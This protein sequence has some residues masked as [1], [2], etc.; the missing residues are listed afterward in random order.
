M[1]V[2]S[3]ISVGV[4]NKSYTHN[5]SFDNNT[6]C[7]FGGVQPLFSQYLSA[8]DKLSGN[9]RQ[10]VR[11]SPMPVP[12][13]GRMRLVNKLRFVP[14]V[15]V[16]PYFEAMLANQYVSNSDTNYLPTSVPL[17]QCK[18][19]TMIVLSRF[20][21]CTYYKGSGNLTPQNVS[22]TDQAV[23]FFDNMTS[24]QLT[25]LGLTLNLTDD[26]DAITFDGAD[27]V[28]IDDSITQALTFRLTDM[29]KRLRSIM[30]GLGYVFDLDSSDNVSLLPL[31]AY[32]KAYFDA[33]VPKR[34]MQW[35][36]TNCFVLIDEIFQNYVTNFGSLYNS[37]KS[38]VKAAAKEFI[39]DLANSWYTS[40]DDF[41]SAH[42]SSVSN[43]N[44]VKALSLPIDNLDD[45]KDTYNLVQK[46]IETYPTLD[47]GLSDISEITSVGLRMLSR[48]SKWI[49]KDTVIGKRVSEW[50]KV[51]YGADVA[52]N[53][54]KQSV[55][56][57][58]IVVNCNIND[59]FSTS[60]TYSETD[61]V[62][63]YLGSYAGKGLGFGDGNFS[64]T[65][66][67]FGFLIVLTCI[68][69]DSGYCQGIDP[70]L[71][72]IDRFTLPCAEFDA[73]GYEVTSKSVIGD[74]NNL[75][76]GDQDVYS[77]VGFGF[78]PR[79]SGFKCR[80]NIVNGDMSR[81]GTINSYSPYY[82]DR[83]LIDNSISSYKNSD[84]TYQVSRSVAALP[85]ASD[86]WRYPTRYNWLGNFNRIF[87]NSGNTDF[88]AL[89]KDN[90]LQE[91]PLDDNFLVQSVI[92][93][94]LTNK[95]KPIAMSY[96]TFDEEVDSS[97]KTVSNQ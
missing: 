97:S 8:G 13:F 47:T 46:N 18:F 41:V 83:I 26:S 2:F 36:S 12:T 73:L 40:S 77:N 54:F 21:T 53:F 52:S 86:I 45:Y 49:N 66:P 11:L 91:T 20:A 6:S 74:H 82:L 25:T 61:G 69:P 84:G 23:S 16:C 89:I 93:L 35:T 96:D 92:S 70:T 31:L 42:I 63:D 87:Y 62:G 27:Y 80:R 59:I 55:S 48:F 28:I 15:D 33:Y 72:G 95:L 76:I 32:Y 17:V 39:L 79:Y 34:N 19:L 90:D 65:A 56:L 4:A 78:V 71:F 43:Q 24:E 57:D 68:V 22:T 85:V 88:N 64:F 44:S 1:S 94:K 5:L 81:R 14:I 38:R 30:L 3:K 29:G 75:F 50:L 10:L 9:L 7:N 51:H 37:S 60:D 58:D 67:T